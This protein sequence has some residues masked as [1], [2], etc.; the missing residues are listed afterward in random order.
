ML[1]QILIAFML[2]HLRKELIKLGERRVHFD[3]RRDTVHIVWIPKPPA[4]FR[5]IISSKTGSVAYYAFEKLCQLPDGNYLG[6][7]IIR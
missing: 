2:L 7:A 5:A 1:S 6:S 3:A 4:L